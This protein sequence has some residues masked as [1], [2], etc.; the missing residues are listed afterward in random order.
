[1]SVA[2]LPDTVVQRAET[3]GAALVGC[4]E[5]VDSTHETAKRARRTSCLNMAGEGVCDWE[6][7]AQGV[8]ET[9]HRR[10]LR[11][12]SPAYQI[13]RWSAEAQDRERCK[14]GLG[15]LGG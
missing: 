9:V 12:G 6:Q 11:D 3:R 7:Q 2:R 5:C 1:M 15:E 13:V 4:E 10:T 14:W 8:T